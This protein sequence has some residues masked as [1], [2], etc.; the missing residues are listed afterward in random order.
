MLAYLAVSLAG[1]LSHIQHT[2]SLSSLLAADRKQNQS[3]PIYGPQTLQYAERLTRSLP[4]SAKKK[5]K[6]KKEEESK[7]KNTELKSKRNH[8]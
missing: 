5:K 3:V 6:G 4:S 7:K 1:S 8:H 2:T